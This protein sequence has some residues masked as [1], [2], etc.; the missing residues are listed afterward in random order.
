MSS[1]LNPASATAARIASRVSWNAE[2]SIWRPI[3]DCPT[4]EI[5]ARRS[6][7]S[8]IDVAPRSSAPD[9]TKLGTAK[10]AGPGS[11]PTATSMPTAASAAAQP[12]N[13][14][15]TRTPG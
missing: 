3:A 8:P 5:N 12:R 14:P 11:N 10:P 4:P 7:T 6:A 9:A 15:V 13:R 2:R 1:G